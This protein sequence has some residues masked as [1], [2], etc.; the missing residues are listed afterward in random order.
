[1][2]ETEGGVVFVPG[3]LPGE[4][5]RIALEKGPRSKRR[6]SGV[7][8]GRLVAILEPSAD[9]VTPRCAHQGRCGGCPLMIL[10][11]DAQARFKARAA[12]EATGLA[13][14][15]ARAG[16]PPR[17]RRRARLAFAKGRLGY[18]H[19]RSKRI[20]DIDACPILERSLEDALTLVR[21]ALLPRLDG[22]GELTLVR[23]AEQP[24]L[25][26]RSET[27]QSAEVYAWLRE[28]V[29]KGQLAGVSLAVGG[30]APAVMGAPEEVGLD[31]DGAPLIGPAFGFSQ[32]NAAVNRALV[33]RVV[34]LAAPK[35]AAVLEL[36]A[37][38]GNLTIALAAQAATLVAVE[39]QPEA[40]RALEDNLGRRGLR[41]RVIAADAAEGARRRKAD[42]VVLDP[43]RAGARDAIA[44]IV[45]ADP[46]RI[47]YVSCDLATLRRDLGAL[48]ESG[49][50]AVQA[51]AF[52]MFPETA[53]LETVV[54]LQKKR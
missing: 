45:A 23:G 35:G 11:A 12:S 18:R 54:L 5:V 36:Y 6:R 27:P 17:Y 30:T 2:V 24:A 4:R 46:A 20:V 21:R 47:V 10:S 39:Q 13:V 15:L 19:P 33:D 44:A 42:V 16:A 31:A 37:G 3:A 14:T 34:A 41:A 38:H 22:D 50:E 1:M 52:D 48:R 26:I 40:A 51:D 43:P 25:W 8:R 28:A 53:H 49:Y 9:R 32:A 7:R 29:A